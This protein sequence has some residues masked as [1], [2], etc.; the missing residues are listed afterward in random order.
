MSLLF[1]IRPTEL[2]NLEQKRMDS[3]TD[4]LQRSTSAKKFIGN[5]VTINLEAAAPSNKLQIAP[6]LIKSGKSDGF[7]YNQIGL[8]NSTM[9]P[10]AFVLRLNKGM[11]V[12]SVLLE[13]I[14][15]ITNNLAVVGEEVVTIKL[16]NSESVKEAPGSLLNLIVNYESEGSY[17]NGQ[18]GLFVTLADQSHC[19]FISENP[20][21]TG[22]IIKSI[23]FTEPAHVTKI[24]KLL[25]QQALFNSMISSCVR[26]QNTRQDFD[27]YMFEINVV[28][29]QFI[30]IFVE[31][32][33]KETIVTVELDLTDARQVNCKINGSDQLFDSKLEN[34]IHR[35]F[36]KT[37]SIPMILR[38]LIKYWDNEAQEFQRHQKRLYNNGIYGSV[39]DPKSE[40]DGKKDEK[41]NG[42]TNGSLGDYNTNGQDVSGAF[43]I[44][45]INKN[46][47][48]FKTS[49]Q[50]GEK[51][52]R[53]EPEAN[54]DIFDQRAIKMPRVMG[55]DLDEGNEMMMPERSM[56]S[57]DLINENS[58]SSSLSSEGPGK[59]AFSSKVGTPSHKSLD[60]FEFNDPSPPPAGNTVM[61]PLQ[62]PL[63]EERAKK[64]PTPRASPSTSAPFNMEKR[65]HDN[66]LVPKNQVSGMDVS[67]MNSASISI[68][69]ISSSSGFVYEKPKSEKKKKRKREDGEMGSPAMVKKKSSESLSGSP[70]K[71]SSGSSQVMGKPR[72][73]PVPGSSLDPDDL[74]FLN[75]DPQVRSQFI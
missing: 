43:D 46:E 11:P 49:E 51:R 34:Y 65:V 1:F 59:K 12:S 29:L 67:Q 58:A 19:Y 60:V 15:K 61:V 2:L 48:F 52:V 71:K 44:C 32:P 18:K 45:G 30:Q 47:I 40:S 8:H 6:L 63:A 14:K 10:A 73:S 4:A 39:G 66:E 69:P 53:Q 13:E 7:S 21:L 22:T 75:F 68:T 56:L 70:S 20:E 5:S 55:F 42:D 37:M 41:E 9:L 62:S 36:Q 64:I 24:I 50:K 16:E 26:K 31:H 54:V 28:S 57:D 33:I 27:S 3:L 17:E 23:Q 25:R 74:S 35:V 38:S 72:K